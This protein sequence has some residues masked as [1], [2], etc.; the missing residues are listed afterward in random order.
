M[1]RVGRR[2]STYHV[3]TTWKLRG[4]RSSAQDLSQG[5]AF[6]LPSRVGEVAQEICVVQ[7]GLKL[8]LMNASPQKGLDR[9]ACHTYHCHL[10]QA[11]LAESGESSEDSWTVE[12]IGESSTSLVR[13]KI[14]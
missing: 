12:S 13:G 14:N 5:R 8:E 9:G 3:I 4:I 10:A 11:H 6:G 1:I 7:A 2:G